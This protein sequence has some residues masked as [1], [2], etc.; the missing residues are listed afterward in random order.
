MVIVLMCKT[1]MPK[2]SNH[3]T[4][5][6]VVGDGFG[7]STYFL[8][9]GQKT[10]SAQILSRWTP[11]MTWIVESKLTVD[12]KEPCAVKRVCKM[13]GQIHTKH[14]VVEIHT[15]LP[16]TKVEATNS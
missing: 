3:A 11:A 8:Y 14:N 6:E 16:S 7:P 4:S 1:S 12:P 5:A 9:Q 2:K 15:V 10:S 13:P